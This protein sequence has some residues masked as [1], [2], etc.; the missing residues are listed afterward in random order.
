M[1]A[2]EAVSGVTGAPQPTFG[3]RAVLRFELEPRFW[4]A[5]LVKSGGQLLSRFWRGLPVSGVEA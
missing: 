3:P 1:T 4:S 5:M 2:R